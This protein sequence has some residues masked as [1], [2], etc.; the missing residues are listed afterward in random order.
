MR[1]TLSRGVFVAAAATS[2][3][4]LY[5]NP[6]L[7]DTYANGSSSGSPGVL[8][9]NTVQAPV[10]VPVNVCGNTVDVVAGLNPA[11]GNS[12]ANQADAT[13]TTDTPTPPVRS[14]PEPGSGD[15][16]PPAGEYHTL[17]A[18]TDKHSTPPGHGDQEPGPTPPRG[19]AMPPVEHM[20]PHAPELAQTGTGALLATS[21]ASAALI[22]GGAVLY[23]RARSTARR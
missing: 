14:T 5:A 3:L 19:A 11:F 12:C 1:Q 4:S 21:A 17:P 2:V 15:E 13:A 8:S 18:P 7:A 6:A 10:D 23:R 20:Q 22:A 16:Q 9:G